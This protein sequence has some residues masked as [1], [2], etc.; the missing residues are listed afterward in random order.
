MAYKK[1]NI[2]D[3][4]DLNYSGYLWASDSNKPLQ[5]DGK[6]DKTLIVGLPFIIEGNLWSEEDQIS[7]QI[8]NIDGVY[9][10]A[11]IDMKES[12][13]IELEEKEYLAH[14]LQDEKGGTKY[15]K[16]KQAWLPKADP[17]S[18]DFPVLQPA[19]EAFVGFTYKNDQK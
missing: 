16:M 1:I 18:N 17:L 5:I 7:I 9:H 4:P 6:L 12:T 15:L 8:Q 11:H 3:I 14:D 10:I 19:W 2:Q 13:T